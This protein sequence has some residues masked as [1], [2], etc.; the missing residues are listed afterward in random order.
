MLRLDLSQLDCC[1]VTF[2]GF[3]Q[4][5]IIPLQVVVNIAA[6]LVMRLKQ[7]NEIKTAMQDLLQSLQSIRIDKYVNSRALGLLAYI[8]F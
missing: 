4:H 2:A 1:D 8:N 5:S 6:H 7:F 3:P